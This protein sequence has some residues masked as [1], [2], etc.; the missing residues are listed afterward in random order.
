[1]PEVSPPVLWTLTGETQGRYRVTL[2]K[3]SASDPTVLLKLWSTSGTSTDNQ[4]TIPAGHIKTGST[5]RIRVEVWDDVGRV[6]DEHVT[7]EKDITYV[8]D[9]SPTSPTSFTA[10]PVTNGPGVVCFWERA[11]APDY[12]CLKKDGV[13]VEPRIVPGDVFISGDDYQFTYYGATPRVNSTYEIEAVTQSGAGAPLIHSDN[14]PTDPAQ[15]SPVGIWLID[16]E[17]GLKCQILGK[18]EVDFH[19]GESANTFEVIGS[20][21]LIRITDIIRG[22]VGSISGTL[23]SASDRNNFIELKGRLKDLRLVVG[24]LSIPI[25]LEDLA[26]SP[27]PIPGDL[28]YKVN[29]NFFQSGPPWPV[30]MDA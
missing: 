8:R 28:L 16:E 26:A 13:E 18:E 27:T 29:F 15:T 20:Q 14:N 6:A 4:V 22:Y 23:A 25:R 30:D 7:A 17:D 3:L 11:A 5:Y 10:T 2:F 24:D 12:F 21:A 19:V 1:V 9:G